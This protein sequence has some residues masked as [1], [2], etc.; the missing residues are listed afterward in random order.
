MCFLMQK[1]KN[2]ILKYLIDLNTTTVALFRGTRGVL[3][4]EYL[5]LQVLIIYFTSMTYEFLVLC[6]YIH[7]SQIKFKCEI[8]FFCVYLCNEFFLLQS[9]LQSMRTSFIS[10][11]VNKISDK[12]LY[13][14][15]HILD[16][17]AEHCYPPDKD[18]SDCKYLHVM[19]AITD[20]FPKCSLCTKQDASQWHTIYFHKNYRN[21]MQYPDLKMSI[22]QR[23]RPS[24][25]KTNT[26]AR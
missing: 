10:I 19:T 24:H 1:I 3:A 21:C 5:S 20:M 17:S 4:G 11:C 8:V 16:F 23:M 25:R 9:D 7:L 15:A 13:L 14:V 18:K 2:K 26:P 12:L 22:K 6:A